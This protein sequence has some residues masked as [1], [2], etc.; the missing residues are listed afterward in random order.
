MRLAT[1]VLVD[2][3]LA[4]GAPAA[5]PAQ[6]LTPLEPGGSSP[7]DNHKNVLFMMADDLRPAIGA[8]NFPGM[9]TPNMDRLANEG[10]L[11]KRAYVQLPLCSPSRGTIFT[12]RRPDTTTMYQFSTDF[13]KDGANGANWVTL[14]QYFRQKGYY[15]TGTGKLFHPGYPVNMDAVDTHGHILSFD[16]YDD[17]ESEE[18]Q[19]TAKPSDFEGHDT[20]PNVA[21]PAPNYHFHELSPVMACEGHSPGVEQQH[22]EGADNVC[23]VDIA[24]AREKGHPMIDEV[25][26]NLA[27]MQLRDASAQSKPWFVAVGFKRPHAPWVASKESYAKYT[28]HVHGPTH[29]SSLNAEYDYFAWTKV[30]GEIFD[31][32][33]KDNPGA[34]QIPDF[35]ANEYRRGYYAS[36]TDVDGHVGQMLDELVSRQLEKTTMVV[37][38]ADHGF[39]L[40]ENNMWGKSAMVY[41][42]A[43][44]VPLLIKVPWEHSSMGKRVQSAVES[45]GLF[46]TLVN[47]AGL[48]RSEALSQL[49]GDSFAHLLKSGE[50]SSDIEQSKAFVQ[51][52]HPVPAMGTQF[53]VRTARWCYNEMYSGPA[54]AFHV[55]PEILHD[56]MHSPLSRLLG[57]ELLDC[58]DAE[59]AVQGFQNNLATEHPTKYDSEI[60]HLAQLLRSN[61]KELPPYDLVSLRNR[62]SWG[63]A[64]RAAKA[65]AAAAAA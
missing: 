7:R 18:R 50:S 17:M 16:R 28:G 29:K 20:R 9:H 46:N 49:Q 47:L 44:R 41:E 43:A 8:Y 10:T 25:N 13:R 14:P 38:T 37:L 60:D 53:G 6:P 5:L 55:T 48:D 64:A 61:Y 42:A 59:A 45:V 4:L 12:G 36:V 32:K 57:I 34:L 21:G 2:A 39:S 3:V 56:Q 11:F 52:V 58:S 15:V 19:R 23:E 27:L 51:T 31:N 22:F 54:G 65:R 26:T 40:G 62:T 33:N 35:A 63:T 24:K 1:A 30:A